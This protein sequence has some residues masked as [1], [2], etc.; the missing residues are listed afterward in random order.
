MVWGC[1]GRR[2]AASACLIGGIIRRGLDRLCVRHHLADS[3]ASARWSRTVKGGCHEPVEEV[4]AMTCSEFT[5][6]EERKPIERSGKG[7][8][9]VLSRYEKL[10]RLSDYHPR[11]AVT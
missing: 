3:T 5:Y 6:R 10:F 2:L 8:P 11:D 7:F 1:V 4:H 9:R